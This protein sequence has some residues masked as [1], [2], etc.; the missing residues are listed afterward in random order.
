MP[1]KTFYNLDETKK[2]KLINA[3]INEFSRVEYEKVSINQIIIHAEIAR[4]S[5]YMYFT[6]KEDLMKYLL[7]E[8][9]KKLVKI[10]NIAIE[11]NKGDLECSF[12]DIYDKLKNYVKKYKNKQFFDNIFIFINNNRTKIKPPE[13]Y[14]IDL[15]KDKIDYSKYKKDV[16]I[17]FNLLLS[18]LFKFIVMALDNDFKDESRSIYLKTIHII[19]NG[20]NKEENNDKNI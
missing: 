10:M 8:H 4:G 17:A 19:C 9:Y 13:L 11:K 7:S 14:F 16:D 12:S 1:S 18:N 5:F 15:F 20:I 6:D 2:E 3:A